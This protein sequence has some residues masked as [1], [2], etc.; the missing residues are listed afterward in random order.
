MK[1]IRIRKTFQYNGLKLR[2]VEREEP[3]MNAIEPVT[4]TRVIAPNGGMIPI[5]PTPK[6]LKAIQQATIEALNSF[7]QRG[8]NVIEELTK[9][10]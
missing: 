8:A 6:T 4:M 1:I 3:Y 2:I 7:K 9:P 5:G 10:I